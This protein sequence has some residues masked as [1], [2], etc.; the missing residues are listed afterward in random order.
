MFTFAQLT[1]FVAVAEELHFG[2]AAERLRMTQPPLSRQIQLLEKD[3]GAEL[4]DRS[5]RS[6]K[7]TRAGRA[8]LVDARRLLQQ[9]ERASLAVRR[10]SAGTGGVVRLGFTGASVH[11]GLPRVL[12][13]ARAALPEVD[14]EL[15]ELVTMDQVEA[16]SEGSLDL[17]MVRPPITRP[18]LTTRPFLREGLVVALPAEHRLAGADTVD[19]RALHGEPLVMHAPVEARYFHELVTA[20][21]H[22][23]GVVPVVTQYMTT[24]HSILA[25]VDLG[26]GAAL[27][28][29]SAAAMRFEHVA[30]RPLT[31]IAAH[32]ELTLVWRQGNENPAL[33]K[34]LD[35]LAEPVNRAAGHDTFPVSV[36]P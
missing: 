26:W 5:N 20:V 25:L 17:G 30:F 27:V 2:R 1:A 3:L 18:D 11:S 36:H 7:L 6:V 8:F 4:F 24:V 19:V 16:L 33:A 15:R 32:A 13:T 10:V 34:L 12:A 14:L 31:G 21:L 28:P 35:E 29:E 9:A 23:A 22:R